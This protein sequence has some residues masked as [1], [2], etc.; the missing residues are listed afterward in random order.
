MTNNN[1]REQKTV[2][3]LI[4]V[5]HLLFVYTVATYSDD[6]VY[7]LNKTNYIHLAHEAFGCA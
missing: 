5:P 3:I 6:M 1:V 2:L 7:I 4:I